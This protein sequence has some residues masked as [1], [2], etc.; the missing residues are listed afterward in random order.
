MQDLSVHLA[1]LLLADNEFSLT[2]SRVDLIGNSSFVSSKWM[3]YRIQKD[4]TREPLKSTD[5]LA[6]FRNVEVLRLRG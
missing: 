2:K 1:H 6:D 5:F 3:T 4:D